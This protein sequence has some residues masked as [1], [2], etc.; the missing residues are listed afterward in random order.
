M[1]ILVDKKRQTS[2]RLTL[3]VKNADRSIVCRFCSW[4]QNLG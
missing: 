3:R 4:L 2:F 1:E